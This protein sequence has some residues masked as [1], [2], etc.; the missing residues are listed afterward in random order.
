MQSICI[1]WNDQGNTATTDD[2][3]V[4]GGQVLSLLRFSVFVSCFPVPEPS[5]QV[6]DVFK[7]IGSVFCMEFAYG[8]G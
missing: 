1:N 2:F 4:F 3:D 6:G 8:N 5:K 7:C